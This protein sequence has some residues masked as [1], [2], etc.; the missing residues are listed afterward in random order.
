MKKYLILLLIVTS[1]VSFPASFPVTKD[2]PQFKRMN[3]LVAITSK[4]DGDEL[5][6]NFEIQCK[7]PFDF[8]DSVELFYLNQE[9]QTYKSFAVPISTTKTKKKDFYILKGSFKMTPN[10]IKNWDVRLCLKQDYERMSKEQGFVIA[11]S[12]S[13]IVSEYVD[14]KY[15]SKPKE[16]EKIPEEGLD[17]LE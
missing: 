15:I 1:H 2:A 11:G 8:I 10:L 12:W 7:A 9:D 17:L 16:K 6:I 14:P 13:F 3:S 4:E 5:K